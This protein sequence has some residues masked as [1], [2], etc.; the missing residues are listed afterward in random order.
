MSLAA[1]QRAVAELLY[2]RASRDAFEAAPSAWLAARGLAGQEARILRSIDP[3][4]ARRFHEI[5]ARD[6][7][8]FVRVLFPLSLAFHGDD[9][10]VAAY[11]DHEPYGHD[12][13]PVEAARFASF[14]DRA[15]GG[16]LRGLALADLAAF[17]AATL[18][19]RLAP[20]RAPER[21]DAPGGH[22][23]SP[24]VRLLRVRTNLPALVEALEA[25]A[26]PFVEAGDGWVAL[27]RESDGGVTPAAL[28]VEVGALL[29]AL[30]APARL[31]DVALRHGPG[32]RA[33]LAE[34]VAEGVIVPA[35]PPQAPR[36]GR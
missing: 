9:S 19:L 36:P 11:L 35:L 1:L 20:D 28:D 6:R 16:G 14:A 25:G 2:D 34:L 22:V 29:A 10:L 4:R 27:R 24:D 30:A 33:L 5:Q 21:P 13:F 15:A 17:E 7:A 3:A 26:E 31:E 8:Y 23:L 32:A 18:S 12:D